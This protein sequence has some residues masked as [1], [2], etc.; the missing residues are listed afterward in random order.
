MR[1]SDIQIRDPFIVQVK[2]EGKYYL[3]GTTDKRAWT[4][5]GGGFECYCSADLAEWEGLFPAFVP[6]ADFWATTQFWAPEVHRW[7]GRYFM[8]ASFKADGMHRGTQV[9]AAAGPRGPF[10]PHS[11]GPVTPRDWECLDGTL[12]VDDAGKPWMVFCHEWVQV[13][14]GQICAMPLTNDLRTAAAEPVLLFTA[15]QAPWVVRSQRPR[16]RASMM[17]IQ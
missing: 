14:N 3:Y 6:P 5:P 2:E 13:H 10:L 1:T 4:G 15:S 17:A 16:A 12:F 8:F 11:N 9:L 7:G